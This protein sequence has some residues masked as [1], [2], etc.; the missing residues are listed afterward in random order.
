M[1]YKLAFLLLEC[2][3]NQLPI[4]TSHTDSSSSAHYWLLAWSLAA[5]TV[6]STNR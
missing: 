2:D 3:C 1:V 6:A 4:E 5:A